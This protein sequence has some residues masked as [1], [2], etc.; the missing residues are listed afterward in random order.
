MRRISQT[1]KNCGQFK[2]RLIALSLLFCFVI[3]SLSATIFIIT[4]SNHNCIGSN[5]PVCKQIHDVQKFLDRIGRATIILLAVAV[6]SFTT[7]TTWIKLDSF[8]VYFST[9]VSVKIRLN[10]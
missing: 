4:Q 7:C 5:C 9:P 6:C 10:N 2:R 8:Q 1:N 3:V